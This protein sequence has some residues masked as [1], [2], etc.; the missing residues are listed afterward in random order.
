M[1][2]VSVLGQQST[3]AGTLW[4]AWG[5]CRLGEFQKKDIVLYIL[6]KNDRGNLVQSL[7]GAG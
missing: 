2:G 5:W 4:N 3:D 7:L 6:M 1:R